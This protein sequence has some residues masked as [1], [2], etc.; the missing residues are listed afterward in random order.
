M[1]ATLRATIALSRGV[2][3]VAFW[4]ATVIF[5]VGCVLFQ[6]PWSESKK[7]SHICR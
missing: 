5:V 1:N 4:G 2:S 7:L 3:V 6:V